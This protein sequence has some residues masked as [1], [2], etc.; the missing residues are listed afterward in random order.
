MG[1]TSLFTL[2]TDDEDHE[3][4]IAELVNLNENAENALDTNGY[5]KYDIKWY[6]FED[7][8]K[9]FS[10]IYPHIVFTLT[11]EV[12]TGDVQMFY[13]K[14]GKSQNANVKHVWDDY[15]ESKLK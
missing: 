13:F 10:K 9:E 14:D 15:D 6:D 12:E 5:P 1:T 3:S 8:L 2:Q 7:D 11:R 4:I